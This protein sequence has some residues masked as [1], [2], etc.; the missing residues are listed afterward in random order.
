[1]RLRAV[2]LAGP[3]LVAG[4]CHAATAQVMGEVSARIVSLQAGIF[5]APPEAGRRAAPETLSGWIHVPDEPVTLRA[6]GFQ[7]PAVLGMGFGVRFTLAPGPDLPTRYTVRHPPIPPSGA[8]AQSWN[9]VL[10]GDATDS[11]FFQ[12][13]IPEELQPGD[14]SFTI[15]AAGETLFTVAFTVVPPGTL[16][17]IEALCPRGE[18]LSVSPESPAAAG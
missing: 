16:P 17:E 13:D 7:A 15:E 2:F 18:L 6:E 11:A 3:V 14:W 4:L 8:T 10:Q 5:C 1:M 9:S 12:F